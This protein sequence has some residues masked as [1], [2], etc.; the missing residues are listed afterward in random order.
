M[1][2]VSIFIEEDRLGSRSGL[3]S[4]QLRKEPAMIAPSV[5]KMIG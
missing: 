1:V 5:R 3:K 2:G 4:N